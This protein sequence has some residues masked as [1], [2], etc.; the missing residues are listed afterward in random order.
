MKAGG[1]VPFEST[2]PLIDWTVKKRNEL[3]VRRARGTAK[4]RTIHPRIQYRPL[5]LHYPAY[6]QRRDHC[7]GQYGIQWRN[8]IS[9]KFTF[10]K[11]AVHSEE[12]FIH[13]SRLTSSDCATCFLVA[14]P[15]ICYHPLPGAPG[16]FHC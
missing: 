1:S 11:D 5:P 15:E 7:V 8:T 14:T 16:T 2:V 12:M 6:S 9:N 10:V 3:T 4:I 13:P